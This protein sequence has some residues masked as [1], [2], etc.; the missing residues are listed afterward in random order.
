MTDFVIFLKGREPIVVN[1]LRINSD[2]ENNPAILIREGI[3][4]D[5]LI[6][7]HPGEIQAILRAEDFQFAKPQQIHEE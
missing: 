5:A 2:E 3:R 1:G 6:Y 4:G 7:I